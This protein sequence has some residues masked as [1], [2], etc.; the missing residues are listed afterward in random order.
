MT[1]LLS[2]GLAG[3]LG[4]VLV[5]WLSRRSLG[6]LEVAA[7]AMP[8]GLGVTSLLFTGA[9]GAGAGW[10]GELA[11]ELA[12]LSL[13]TWML[14]R[15]AAPRRAAL[16]LDGVWPRDGLERAALLLFVLVLG[17]A[18]AQVLRAMNVMV[19]GTSDALTQW[20][21]KART[22]SRGGADGLASLA[23]PARPGWFHGDY[24]L[25]WAASVA[26]IWALA[27]AEPPVVPR[28]VQLVLW[29]SATFLAFAFVRARAGVALAAVAGAAVAAL[30]AL[31]AWAAR[32]Y[33]DAP[34]ACLLLAGVV[35]LSA[36]LERRDD[37]PSLAALAGLLAGL[38][39][40]TKNEGQLF[41]VAVA[42]ALVVARQPVRSLLR[43]ASGAAAP[44][45]AVLL[46][47]RLAPMNDL[48]AG[49]GGSSSP[50]LDGARHA[51]VWSAWARVL[52]DG[53]AWGGTG[54]VVLLGVVAWG[55]ARPRPARRTW[56]PA[57]ALFA[58]MLAGEYVV[59]L[60]TPNDLAWQLRFSADRLF[61]QLAPAALVL[62]LGASTSSARAPASG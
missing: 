31:H 55:L 14:R 3:A 5:E 12:A 13:A 20:L 22:L 29:L 59:Y 42:V 54:L 2:L 37:E 38:A 17:L 51:E 41:L 11:L 53:A 21:L 25:L 10:F 47:K 60:G 52:A 7:L 16:A 43:F 19:W 40:W 1:I 48:L 24:P 34:L 62:L 49:R 50:W 45:V 36:Q 9:L 35:L 46:L 28:L 61:L 4:A 27:G 58:V 26:R 39:A 30:P 32:F 15:S 18:V 44:V 8:V 57:V 33:A 56:L 6:R 23:S